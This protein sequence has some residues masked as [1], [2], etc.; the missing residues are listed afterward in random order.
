[1]FLFIISTGFLQNG[2]SLRWVNHFW[3][4]YLQKVCMQGIAAVGTFMISMHIE[5]AISSGM[6]FFVGIWAS[7]CFAIFISAISFWISAN[8]WLTY[9]IFSSWFNLPKF[10]WSSFLFSIAAGR[11]KFFGIYCFNSAFWSGCLFPSSYCF[12]SFNC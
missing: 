6:L 8:C 5:Q 3:M 10:F 9:S 4:H 2:H 11:G 1:M 12:F 7:F